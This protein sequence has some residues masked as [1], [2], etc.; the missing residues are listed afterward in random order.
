MWY[1]IW[2]LSGK[3]DSF[4]KELDSEKDSVLGKMWNDFCDHCLDLEM[5]YSG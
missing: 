1:F 5:F 3:I 2:M 4:S